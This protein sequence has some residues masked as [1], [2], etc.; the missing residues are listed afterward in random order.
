LDTTTGYFFFG[1]LDGTQNKNYVEYRWYWSTFS[2]TA[3]LQSGWNSPFFRFQTADEKIYISPANTSDDIYPLMREYTQWNSIGLKIKGIGNPMVLLID[4]FVIQ[5][6]HFNDYSK[7]CQGLYLA[8]S[9]YLTTPLGELDLGSGTIEFWLRPDYTFSAYDEFNR[10]KNRSFFSIN[11]VINEVFGMVIT[12]KG[13][14]F[15][16]GNSTIDLAV[17]RIDGLSI[18]SIDK[19]YH[20]GIV[21]SNNGKYISSDNSTIKLYINNYLVGSCYETWDII[22][23]KS[24]KFIFGGK[25]PLAILESAS[26]L[27]ITS[28][29]AVV[30]ELK[31]YNY[32]KTDFSDSLNLNIEQ[33]MTNDLLTPDE[34]IEISKDNVTFYRVG[35]TNLPFLFEQVPAETIIPV[36][37]K[38]IVPNNLIGS[39]SRTSKL[40]I[41]WDVGV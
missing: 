30:S 31:I 11:N 36:Y 14:F 9:D 27:N 13:I 18:N 22:D 19:L 6:N 37:I 35:D 7:F 16:F 26:T 15:Y 10:I 17:F 23:N 20:F 33:F 34:M 25:C 38:S 39:E 29:D 40:S 1:G 28:I 4:G 2:G 41:S 3:A 12:S 24:F 8:G 5:R 21:F 32:C